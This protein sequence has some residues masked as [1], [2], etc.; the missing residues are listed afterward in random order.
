MLLLNVFSGRATIALASLLGIAQGQ[1]AVQPLGPPV[2]V[3]GSIDALHKCGVND[4]PDIPARAFV[5]G[6]GSTH[7]IVGST[8]FH[9]MSGPTLF[10]QTRNCTPAWNSTLDPDPSH[11]AYAEWLD[12]PHVFDN[13]T[14]IALVHTEYD[15]MKINCTGSY[16]Y[17]WTVSIGLAVSHDWGLTWQHARPPPGHLVAA[18]PYEFNGTQIASGW[19][20][21]SSI[22][23][24]PLDNYYYFGM[25]NR[26]QVGLQAPGV[27]FARTQDLTDPAS[28]R[29]WGGSEYNITFTSAYTMAPSDAPA[30]VCT[31]T[32][33]PS[34]MP[35]GLTWSTY[36][37]QFVVTLDCIQRQNG[38]YIAYSDDL[39][40]WS[41]ATQFYTIPDLP[42]P[43]KANVTSMTYPTL[44]DPSG[45]GGSNFNTIGQNASLLWVSIGHSPYTDGRR[46]WATP[47]QFIKGN[48]TTV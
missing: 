17:C 43:V 29:A 7:M 32:N 36:L 8:S 10:N 31:V 13:G 19:G 44:L 35:S 40:H 1:V 37:Q 20:D 48:S 25:W 33:L 21:P 6:D 47:V 39:I 45:Q 5:A 23:L 14:V 38:V 28:W 12:S 9:W 22:I 26:D 34:C 30:H 4:V 41:T 2:S 11:Y 46:V 15:A 16:P 3:W 42:P 18:V 24:N 27:C